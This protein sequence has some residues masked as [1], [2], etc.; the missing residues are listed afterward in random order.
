MVCNFLFTDSKTPLIPNPSN[1]TLII[2]KAKLYHNE[3]DKTLVSVN[4][5]KRVDKAT[6][7]IPT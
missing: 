4:S 1:A 7:K 5:S 3:T 6:R 2:I